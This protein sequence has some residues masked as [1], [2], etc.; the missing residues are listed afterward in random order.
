[1]YHAILLSSTRF[2][3]VRRGGIHRIANHLRQQGWDVEVIDFVDFWSS[4]ELIELA[5]SRIKDN[6]RL[7][8]LSYLSN[9]V[10]NLVGINDFCE[11]A[12]KLNPNIVVMSGGQVE[13]LYYKHTDYHVNGYGEHAL[14][15]LLKYLFSNGSD[16]GLSDVSYSEWNNKVKVLDANNDTYKA[17]PFRDPMIKYEKRDF[18]M[19]EEWGHLELSR[20]CKFK[21][22]FCFLP[23]LGVRGDFTRTQESFKEHMLH[24]YDNWGM[25]NYLISDET[26]NDSTDKLT[27]FADVVEELP[28]DP[29][30]AGFVRA[31]LLI[32]RPKD[33]EEM[34]RM[35]L[36]GHF[37]GIESF[38]PQAVKAIG[39]GMH[40]DK[41]KAGLLDVKHWFKERVGK[42]YRG[43]VNLI[44]GLE[45][46][47]LESLYETAA[48]L[49]ENWSD[50]EWGGSELEIQDP[51]DGD[52]YNPS[53]L[54]EKLGTTSYQKMTDEE[55][56][57][58]FEKE[59][60]NP[61]W[62]N[63]ERDVRPGMLWKNEHMN[64]VQACKWSHYTYN[65]YKFGKEGKGK[66]PI[67]LKKVSACYLPYNYCHDNGMPMNVDER[68]AL[69]DTKT[70]KSIENFKN[71][72]LPN[73]VYKKLSL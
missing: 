69:Y 72:F 58:W 66:K 35:G 3:P 47:P 11:H 56:D 52:V 29:Y 46:E 59:Q 12:K 42:R 23:A 45:Y 71:I 61:K 15:A 43:T 18:I 9:R 65:I 14:D 41:I 8:G 31:D 60:V 54:S 39:K 32:S 33:R 25:K 40:P 48:W 51:N 38:H 19:P 28:F 7:V 1:M 26:I 21:C 16:P 20:G 17:Y 55:A 2:M 5:N 53:T 37:Y 62:I 27:K 50:Q 36:L 22:A 49:K 57:Y 67:N 34:V 44:G 6:S 68:L 70:E 64:I 63:T 10:G 24:A 30:F 13:P 4:E 73:Y